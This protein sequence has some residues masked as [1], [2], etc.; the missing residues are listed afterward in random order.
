[1][2]KA[3]FLERR[4]QG[5]GASDVAA[6][7]GLNPFRSAMGVY[8]EKV[9]LK[10]EEDENDSLVYGTLFE[11]I[12]AERFAE[13]MGVKIR[14]MGQEQIVGPEDW[15]FAHPDFEVL[16]TPTE[17][18]ECKFTGYP[19]PDL[20]GEAGTDH[21]PDYYH[22][23]AQWQM[24][25][26]G[27]SVVNVTVL[28]SG[29]RREQR[30]YRVWAD[31]ELQQAALSACRDF[32][33]NHVLP[34]QEPPLDWTTDSRNFVNQR[35]PTVTEESPREATDD[36]AVLIAEYAKTHALWK[37]LEREKE[38]LANEVK[39]AIGPN[40]GLVGP[41]FKVSWSMHA[42]STYTVTRKP[43]RVLH[44]GG[45]LFKEEKRAAGLF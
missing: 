6:I 2:N 40:R 37:G 11:K 29:R 3:E 42:G 27:W 30:D 22:L 9:G 12:I 45:E 13:R 33:V 18:G 25:C 26:K 16:S 4:R 34:Q 23:Q 21:I 14:W 36:E 44:T 19:D 32:W 10:E 7:M 24:L 8:L 39:E 31:A 38:R 35:F 20:W 43:G 41:G 5:I 1:M 28:F 17:G 15:M